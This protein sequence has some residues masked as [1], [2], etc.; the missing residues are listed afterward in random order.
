[1]SASTTRLC[2]GLAAMAIVGCGGASVQQE[3]NEDAP[4]EVQLR[5]NRITFNHR[6][7]F[8]HDS[9]ELLPASFPILDRVAELVG[10]HIEIIRMQ[11]QGHSSTDGE[12]A[13]NE[14]LSTRR[15]AAI[16]DYLRAQGLTI[17]VTSQGYGE[18]YPLCRE[19]TPE[20]HERNRRVE[21]FVD[22]R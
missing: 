6:I 4:L 8:G 13:H 21:F 7:Q 20:C 14:D 18:T 15:A 17:E 19:D 5:G 10:E 9:E 22:E 16:A 12:T 11:V 2:V 1:M 3:M